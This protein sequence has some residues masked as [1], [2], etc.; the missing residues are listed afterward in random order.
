[1]NIFELIKIQHEYLYQ[2]TF[3]TDKTAKIT[4]GGEGQ[5]WG[6][7]S[8]REYF[9]LPPPPLTPQNE[10]R[11][12]YSRLPDFSSSTRNPPK[13]GVVQDWLGGTIPP[14]FCLIGLF[15]FFARLNNEF[16]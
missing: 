5:T 16:S 6:A 4:M 10:D 15:C 11:G 7:K 1:M 3:E 13:Q 8:V 2:M 9:D 14:G 12:A